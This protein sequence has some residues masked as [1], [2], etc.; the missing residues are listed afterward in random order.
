[1][2][3]DVDGHPVLKDQSFQKG[4]GFKGLESEQSLLDDHGDSACT[5][6]LLD[7]AINS[8]IGDRRKRR[9]HFFCSVIQ[10][11]RGLACKNCLQYG[12][13]SKKIIHG[14]QFHS[15]IANHLT[16]FQVE[17]TYDCIF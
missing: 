15:S 13:W 11:S 2:I 1:M 3:T 8:K 17:R 9:C 4:Q 12:H 5:T 14:L 16:L 7:V 6:N 10:K